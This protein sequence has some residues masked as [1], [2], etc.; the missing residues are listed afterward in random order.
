MLDVCRRYLVRSE[1]IYQ[2][3]LGPFLISN[4]ATFGSQADYYS[5]HAA[6]Y[7]DSQIRPRYPPEL[8]ET[9]FSFAGTGADSALDVATGT[10]QSARQLATRY[11][12]VI[13]WCLTVVCI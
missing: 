12:Q 4:M 11:Q 2:E 8:F 13:L 1:I 9:I 7:S 6:L 5:G 10:G 3:S